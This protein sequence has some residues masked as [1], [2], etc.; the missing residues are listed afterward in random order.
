MPIAFMVARQRS[1]TGALNNI[2]HNHPDIAPKGEV[3]HPDE[4]DRSHTSYFSF[5]KTLIEEDPSL[6]LPHRAGQRLDRYLDFIE[7]QSPKKWIL[8]DV[9][10]RSLGHF[11]GFWHSAAETPGMITL[12]KER[13]LKIL[14]LT[15]RNSL[16]L[17]VSGRLAEAN[18]V[19]HARQADTIAVKKI[20]LDPDQVQ[21]FLALCRREMMAMRIG[22][23]SYENKIE[24]DYQRLFAADGGLQNGPKAQI[25]TFFSL[26]EPI[27]HRTALIKQAPPRVRDAIENLD[28]ITDLLKDT[29]NAWM[30][31]D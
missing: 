8:L 6:A 30:L 2:L 25:E 4:M 12:L 3:F 15:R 10:Y 5:F 9:K 11:N 21:H 14:H 23:Q 24:I 20:K 7:Q 22:L 13:G 27:T 29:P 16:A 19:W 28:E 31:E 18:K 26:S 1:G 17:W